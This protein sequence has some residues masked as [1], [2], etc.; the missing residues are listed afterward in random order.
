MT[1]TM[2]TKS[3]CHNCVAAKILLQ[4][5][6]LEYSEVS[7]DDDVRKANFMSAYP[8]VRQ[9]PQIFIG[10]QRVGGLIGLQEAFKRMGI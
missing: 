10:D 4:S 2:Y 5:K 7:L 9:M 1:I 8:E 6:G 3:N